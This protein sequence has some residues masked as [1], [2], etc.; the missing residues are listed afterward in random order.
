MILFDLDGTIANVDAR[1][2]AAN[3]AEEEYILSNIHNVADSL[4]TVEPVDGRL[5]M[6]QFRKE[7][8]SAWW[9]AWQDPDNISGDEPNELV[10]SVLRDWRERGKHIVIVSARN[11][12][13]RA[14]TEEWL[15]K[16]GIHYDALYM[17]PDGDY[18]PDNVFKQELLDNIRKGGED[19]IERVYDDRNQVVDMWRANGIDCI[20]VVPREKGEF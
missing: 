16:Y 6:S 15:A 2:K 20:Q 18:R 9:S 8:R 14:V 17:R 12:K 10:V 4:D 7:C 11:D 13:N 3:Q 5:T 19:L 1:R